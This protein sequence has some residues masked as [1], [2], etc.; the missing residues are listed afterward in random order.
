MEFVVVPL[1][2]L[3]RLYCFYSSLLDTKQLLILAVMP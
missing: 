1:L 2:L 3:M